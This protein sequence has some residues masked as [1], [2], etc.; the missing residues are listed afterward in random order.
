M[1][2]GLSALA[3][4]LSAYLSWHHLMGGAM[5]GC[6]GGS[7]C[8]Q[9]LSSRWSTIAGLLPISGLATGVYLAMLLASFYVGPDT[10]APVRLLAWR[11]MLL[12]IG[13]AAGSAVWFIIVQKWFIRAFCPYCTTT[14]IIGLLLAVL[15]L[16]QALKTEDRGR[17]TEDGAAFGSRVS[18]FLRISGFGFRIWITWG[19][20]FALAGVLAAAQVAFP[21][22]NVYQGG[23]SQTE[24]PAVDLRAV[25]HVGPPDA[26]YVITLLFDYKCPHCQELSFMLDEVVR[27]YSGKLAF[28]LC[29]TPLNTQCNSYVPRDIDAFKDSCELAK[30]GLAV[31]LAKREAFSDYERWIFTFET[32]DRWE[33]R[34]IEA[35]TAKAIELVGQAKFDAALADPWVGRYL[36]SSVQM[37]G[38]TGRPA[39]PKLIFGSR[40]AVPQPNDIDDLLSILQDKDGLAVPEPGAQRNRTQTEE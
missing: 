22:R 17:R 3:L 27:R 8:E 30:I 15:V 14:H 28:V 11:A 31:W 36:Q 1:L 2:S 20:G 39:I 7:P 18:G 21:P 24:A 10:E 23:E 38:N 25:P 40:W 19:T 5:L 16:W 4:G 34:S 9:V 35:A 6:S 13:A 29:P 33:P 37:F 26:T 12:L 32:G